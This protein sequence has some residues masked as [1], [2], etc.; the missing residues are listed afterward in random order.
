[1]TEERQINILRGLQK[2]L[3]KQIE[4]IRRG[5]SSSVRLEQLNRQADV[6]VE[7]IARLKLLQQDRFRG[8]KENLRKTYNELC[9][10][11][12]AEQKQITESL[13]K[14]RKGKKTIGVYQKN[15]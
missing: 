7:S 2:L 13:G 4:L 10:A 14:V 12:K 6:L 9:L 1:V 5:G 3:E 8:N 11:I 15:M